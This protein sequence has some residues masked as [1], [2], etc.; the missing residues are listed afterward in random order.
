MESKPKIKMPNDLTLRD[1]FAKD[2]PDEIPEWYKHT[3]L[4]QKT[5]QSNSAIRDY[6]IKDEQNRYFQ[7]RYYYADKMIEHSTKK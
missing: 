4:S 1:L 2:A 5:F 3:P 6:E 7:W